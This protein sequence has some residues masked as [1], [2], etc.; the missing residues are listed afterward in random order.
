M[1]KIILASASPQRRALLKQ[2]GL[3]F[4]VVKSG[5]C[6]KRRITSTAANLVINNALAKAKDVANKLDSGVVIGCDT[7][8]SAENKIIGK[9]NDLADA[10]IILKFLSRRPQLVYTGLALIDIDNK[11]TL[12]G[13]E[14]TKVYMHKLSDK[15][16]DR[17][18]RKVSPLDKAGAFDIQRYGGLFIKRIDGC[19]YNVVGL[20]LAKLYQMLK[21]FG[22]QILVILLAANLFGCASEYNVATGREDLIMFDN[23][24][25]I[26]MGQS[27]A[28][29][30]EEKYKPV[31]DYALQAKVDEIGQKIVAV[32][33]RKDIN[34]RFKVL[35]EKEVNAVSLPGGYVY[36][37]KGLTDKVDND[38]EIA[39]VIAHEVGHIVAKHIIKKLQA[40][41]GYNLMNILLIPTRNAQA[42][43]GANAAFAAVFLAYSQ[44]DELLADKLAVKYTKLAGY[45]PE[46]VLTL[47]EKLKDEKEIREFSY[48][49]THPYITQRIAM[50]RSQLRG[51]M[52]FIDYINIENKSP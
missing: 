2:I 49:R 10:K 20:P 48:W 44:E 16:I 24:A 46:G 30:F 27:V 35:D 51:G 45:N 32:C 6:E 42:I 12:T 14:K 7:I 4:K 3:K 38:N 41:L 39:G 29:S 8:V 1:R 34:Y 9:P 13:F 15:E 47:L 22:I 31:Q 50:V 28:R 43:Q 18:F 11:K 21:K 37:F 25:E 19:F 36:L 23:E 40:A 5:T 17:Y 33:D 52:D 26:K